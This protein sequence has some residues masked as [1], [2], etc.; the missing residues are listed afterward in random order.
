VVVGAVLGA[1]VALGFAEGEFAA[2]VAEGA[3]ACG[4]DAAPLTTLI[5]FVARTLVP[6]AFASN[7][8]SI[9]PACENV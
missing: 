7:S 8:I 5:D 6:F 1:A 2:P 4:S 3:V 9:F